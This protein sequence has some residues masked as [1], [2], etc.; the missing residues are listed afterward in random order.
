MDFR[1]SIRAAWP[2]SSRLPLR[3]FRRRSKHFAAGSLVELG[4]TP[5]FAYPLQ[6]TN[7]AQRRNIGR[8]LWEFKAHLYM[9][10][11]TQVIDFIWLNPI[12]QLDQAGRIGQIREMEKQPRCAFV[13]IEE[14]AVNPRGV[15]ATRAPLDAMD[16]IA[17]R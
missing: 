10:L 15:E 12:Q 3:I 1:A 5:Q 13:P 16:L 6:K 17:F 2:E 14:N 11:C 4:L 9:A 8:V 7:R